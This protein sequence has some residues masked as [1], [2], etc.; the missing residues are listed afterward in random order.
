LILEPADGETH[1]WLVEHEQDVRRLLDAQ[2]IL[3]TARIMDPPNQAGSRGERLWNIVLSELNLQMTQ[4]T[5]DRWLRDSRFL[6]CENG[7]YIIGVGSSYAKEWLEHRLFDTVKRTLV[8]LS[9][10][11][12]DIEFVVLGEDDS[13]QP[14]MASATAA[15]PILA[16]VIGM[17]E[18]EI[19]PVTERTV[20]KL[21][22]L[23]EEH[24]DIGQ[25]RDAFD[26]V[27]W[28]NVRRLDYVK[29]CLENERAPKPKRSGRL[30]TIR[31]KPPA[32]EVDAETRA[33]QRAALDELRR[34]QRERERA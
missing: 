2:G 20:Q 10:Q 17:Y 28:S 16:E 33:R 11:D 30:R 4:A 34:R 12:V 23:V 25:W 22:A 21:T 15:D 31:E 5:F 1:A 13:D 7:S 24:Q 27:V 9:G 32:E 3:H 19:G 14:G 8:R 29:R 26:A 18:S 6:G